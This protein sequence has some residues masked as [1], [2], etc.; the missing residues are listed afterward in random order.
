MFLQDSV[1]L[2][3]AR[4]AN[5][6]ESLTDLLNYVG[7]TISDVMSDPAIEIDDKM[8]DYKDYIWSLE[9]ELQGI[10]DTMSEITRK[11]Q[12]LGLSFSDFGVA[13]QYLA[14]VEMEPQLAHGLAQL[15]KNCED[16][17]V[18]MIHAS[19]LEELGFEATINDYSRYSKASKKML[20]NRIAALAT[21]QEAEREV[22]SK[23]SYYQYSVEEQIE[24]SMASE[25]YQQLQAEFDAMD[26]NVRLEMGRFDVERTA[27]IRQTLLKFATR[28]V[29]AEKRSQA[30]WQQLYDTI[31]SSMG[32]EPFTGVVNPDLAPDEPAQ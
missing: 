27:D 32:T 29:N 30:I 22:D 2:L 26:N 3:Q 1:D 9:D 21:L 14:N 17:H 6:E 10:S 7:N 8:N 4:M 15:G 13:A 24:F 19:H 12:D 5:T 20:Q 28:Q 23:Q 11:K 31:E 16:M 25:R 18:S